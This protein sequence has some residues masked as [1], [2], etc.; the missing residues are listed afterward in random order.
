MNRWFALYRDHSAMRVIPKEWVGDVRRSLTKLAKWGFCDTETPW[1]FTF[2]NNDDTAGDIVYRFRNKTVTLR[3]ISCL[4]KANLSIKAT[5]GEKGHHLHSST[6]MVEGKRKDGSP[7]TLAV[8]LEDDGKSEKRPE[9]DRRGLGACGHAAFHC[10]VGP[11]LETEPKV[12]V[13]L[14]AM[15]ASE[16]IDWILLHT[17]GPRIFEPFPWSEV[18]LD[19]PTRV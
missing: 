19:S 18:P 2:A 4:S 16:A 8:H 13:P 9:G 10:H 14:P 3:N 1:R 6:A 11:D 17:T 15:S 7:W 5:L 12:R